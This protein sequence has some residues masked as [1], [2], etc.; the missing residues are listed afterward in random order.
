MLQQ[1]EPQSCTAGLGSLTGSAYTSP[2]RQQADRGVET[3]SKRAVR[4]VERDFGRGAGAYVQSFGL[5]ASAPVSLQ[6]SN[7][8]LTGRHRLV[9][10]GG[11]AGWGS[12]CIARHGGA[13]G[14]G[15]WPPVAECFSN[16]IGDFSSHAARRLWRW[17]RW[18]RFVRV[19]PDACTHADAQPDTN[20]I[21]HSD[22]TTQR[23]G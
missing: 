14:C 11:A 19:D 21:S 2:V 17:R 3:S 20:P 18:R 16:I 10:R 1:P 6:V 9:S 5:K 23:G 7:P 22:P 8:R 13:Y 15:T 4:P 12:R